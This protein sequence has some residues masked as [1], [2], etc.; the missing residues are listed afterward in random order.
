MPMAVHADIL[1]DEARVLAEVLS[2]DGKRFVRVD[3]KIS[4]D[5]DYLSRAADMGQRLMT[6]GGRELVEEAVKVFGDR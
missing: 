4:L 1:D 6:M 5:D 3:E 2:L